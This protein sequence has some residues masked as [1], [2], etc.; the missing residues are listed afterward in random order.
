MSF[1][2]FRNSDMEISIM[3]NFKMQFTNNYSMLSDYICKIQ[4]KGV[5]P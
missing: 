2:L 4:K 3:D 5:S 1:A